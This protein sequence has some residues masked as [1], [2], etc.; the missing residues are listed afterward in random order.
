MLAALGRAATPESSFLRLKRNNELFL[1]DFG[2]F[3]SQAYR[4]TA[5]FN[6]ANLS[7]GRDASSRSGILAATRDCLG[8]R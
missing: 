2:K 3:G 6:R 7:F 5:T 4:P 8:R 1:F